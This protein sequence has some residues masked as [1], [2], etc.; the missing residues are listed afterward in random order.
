MSAKRGVCGPWRMN[1]AKRDS[2]PKAA[3]KGDAKPRQ[4]GHIESFHDK[5]RDELPQPRA[6]RPS[7]GGQSHPRDLEDRIQRVTSAQLA[8]LPNAGGSSRAAAT[9]GS[10]RPPGSLRPELP[11]TPKPTTKSNQQNFRSKLSHLRVQASEKSQ[12]AINKISTNDALHVWQ[13]SLAESKKGTRRCPF[14]KYLLWLYARRRRRTAYPPR[15]KPL[16]ARSA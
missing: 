13:H 8:R 15:A 7:L 9:L 3:P 11:S 5:M 6:L 12:P 14:V 2:L 1:Q 16:S 10:G 4:N